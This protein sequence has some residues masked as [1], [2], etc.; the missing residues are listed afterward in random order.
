MQADFEHLKPYIDD[1]C[2]KLAIFAYVW[3]YVSTLFLTESVLFF[4]AN[5]ND[6]GDRASY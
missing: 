4:Y 3:A 6:S 2:T 1:I 5:K